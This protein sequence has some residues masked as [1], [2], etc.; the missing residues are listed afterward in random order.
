MNISG[1]TCDLYYCL[2][3]GRMQPIGL[4]DSPDSLDSL[5]SP[6]SLDYLIQYVSNKITKHYT[7]IYIY[8][9]NSRRLCIIFEN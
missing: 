2:M 9:I 4:P 5:D 6:D 3:I 7:S 8:T 1:H